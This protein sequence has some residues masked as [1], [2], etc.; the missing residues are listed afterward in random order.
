MSPENRTKRAITTLADI[1]NEISQTQLHPQSGSAISIIQ[2]QKEDKK[3]ENI[4]PT[5]VS[6]KLMNDA[7]QEKNLIWK[8]SGYDFS[9]TPSKRSI[10][11][12]DQ[13]DHQKSLI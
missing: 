12:N 8:S 9:K 10:V 11:K 4:N 5:I 6:L 3:E 7:S 1:I 13:N 2:N